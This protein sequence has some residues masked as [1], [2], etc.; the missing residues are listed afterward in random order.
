[1]QNDDDMTTKPRPLSRGAGAI[2]EDFERDPHG[3]D[4]KQAGAKLDA[5][6]VRMDLLLADFPRALRAVAEVATAGAAKYTDHGW[7]RVPDGQRRYTA[8]LG[9]HLL[10]EHC[11]ETHD[12]GTGLPHAAHTAWNALARLELALRT[13]P[14][15]TE[16]RHLV[17]QGE[18]MVAYMQRCASGQWRW[19]IDDAHGEVVGGAG[20][21]SAA[22]AEKAIWAQ[23]DTAVHTHRARS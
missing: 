7:L 1:M 12:A 14:E 6:K 20:Y 4:R 2:A 13:P 15:K 3:V 21:T 19:S 9:R 23:W 10:D 5:G 8:A 16:Q 17:G 11:G 18:G 22:D